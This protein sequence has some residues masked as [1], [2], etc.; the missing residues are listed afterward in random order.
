VVRGAI[1][2]IEKEG[3][4]TNIGLSCD[5]G[6]GMLGAPRLTDC[7]RFHAPSARP[8][9]GPCGA[10]SCPE[11]DT[12]SHC[13]PRKRGASFILLPASGAHPFF[14]S[15]QAGTSFP[16]FS[17]QAGRSGAQRR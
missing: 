11:Q 7:D 10:P 4:A 12:S 1:R 17:P 2:G 5:G 8:F 13:S 9:N 14:F 15:P 16:F 6:A 3:W